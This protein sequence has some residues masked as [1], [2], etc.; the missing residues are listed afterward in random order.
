MGLH[1]K[2]DRVWL[3]VSYGALRMKTKKEDPKAKER[4]DKEG[5]I[6]FERVYEYVEGILDRVT[7]MEDPKFGN[8]WTMFIRDGLEVYGVKLSENSQY[9]R[10]FLEKFPNLFKGGLYQI[11][12]YDFENNTGDRYVGLSIVDKRNPDGEKIQSFYH[13]YEGEGEARTCTLLHNYPKYE[14]KWTDKDELKIFNVRKNKFLREQG[15]IHLKGNFLVGE[16]ETPEGDPLAPA[17]K[18]DLPF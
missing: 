5:N 15:L 2:E 11:R 8:S 14:G 7:F 12:P 13:R 10:S 1:E 17:E 18:D 9:G 4:K 16:A 3:N 6:V